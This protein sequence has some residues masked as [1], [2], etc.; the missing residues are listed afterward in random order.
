[1][2]AKARADSLASDEN[3][4]LWIAVEDFRSAEDGDIQQ[5]AIEIRDK[6]V[7]HLAPQQ[8]NL[9]VS[10]IEQIAATKAFER[11]T[12]DSVQVCFTGTGLASPI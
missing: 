8:V 5:R 10:L 6:F 2:G 4:L 7:S 1:M 11:S 3:L 9:D 12:F